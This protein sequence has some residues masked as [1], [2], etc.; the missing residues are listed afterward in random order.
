MADA[1]QDTKK[2]ETKPRREYEKTEVKLEKGPDGKY[3][4]PKE[5]EKPDEKAYEIEKAAFDK[6]LEAL[7]EKVRKLSDT[8]N[9][10]QDGKEDYE[11]KKKTLQDDFE[12]AKGKFDEL[13]NKQ[14]ELINQIKAQNQQAKENKRNFLLLFC[15]R[16]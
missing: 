3:I 14:F 10:A 7:R 2:Q 1:A 11:A 4:K 5:P 16:F 12:T 6:K 9:K 13:R 15:W 8:I